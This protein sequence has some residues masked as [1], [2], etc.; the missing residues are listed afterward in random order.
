MKEKTHVNK[1]DKIYKNIESLA[2]KKT[3]S[4][5]FKDI[6][7]LNVY[8]VL[9]CLQHTLE[10]NAIEQC[11]KI[12]EHY[13]KEE[14]DKIIEISK[15]IAHY[16]YETKHDIL[17]QLYMRCGYNKKLQQF[18]TPDSVAELAAKTTLSTAKK[19]KENTVFSDFCCGAGAMI[20]SYI[21]VL[22]SKNIDYCKFSYVLNDIDPF[23]CQMAF[24]QLFVIGVNAY[25]TCAD[26][27]SNNPYCA[28]WEGP[29]ITTLLN[30]N[31]YN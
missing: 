11:D 7:N 18:F 22:E 28:D 15:E 1:V 12:L 24:W 3:I 5:V 17:G 14:Q 29:I 9:P 4:E 23:C 27:L 30:E 20:L 19:I 16:V 6:V 26:V 10:I 13:T 2:G 31:F 21:R 25:I 8:S